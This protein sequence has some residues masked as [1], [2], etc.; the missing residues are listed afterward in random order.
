MKSTVPE[1]EQAAGAAPVQM[2]LGG[3]GDPD[4]PW[5]L[6]PRGPLFT[7]VLDVLPLPFPRPRQL[8]PRLAQ[9]ERARPE[10]P[11]VRRP[12]AVL[13]RE[14][15]VAVRAR[16]LLPRRQGLARG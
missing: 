10:V 16:H 3:G 1:A 12:D 13:L 8:L 9:P 11:D 5:S 2:V 14:Q 15:Q 4:P 7:P 6:A